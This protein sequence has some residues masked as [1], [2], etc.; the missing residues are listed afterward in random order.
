MDGK[1]NTCFCDVVCTMTYLEPAVFKVRED[2]KS[3][4]YKNI[5]LTQDEASGWI[6]YLKGDHEAGWEE[7]DTITCYVPNQLV[8]FVLLESL[9]QGRQPLFSS[10]A[11]FKPLS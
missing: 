9:T 2:G 5:L 7:E 10:V 3:W 1:W 6:V 8:L 4:T 11:E